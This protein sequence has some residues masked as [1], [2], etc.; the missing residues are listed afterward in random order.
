MQH[1]RLRA[2]SCPLEL[3]C[4]FRVSTLGKAEIARGGV[5]KRLYLILLLA[6]VAQ[7]AAALTQ[8]QE[9][10]ISATGFALFVGDY[11][12]PACE[13]YELDDQAVQSVWRSAGLNPDRY[14]EQA[15]FRGIGCSSPSA[16]NDKLCLSYGHGMEARNAAR[17]KDKYGDF[18]R[19]AW[20]DFGPG[21]KV[22]PGLLKERKP[23]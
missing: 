23:K 4:K 14:M 19:K 3:F 15:H 17:M 12:Y 20:E 5:M 6:T 13:Q 2:T 9:R 22:Q 16:V 8:Q 11:Y 10:V 18:C 21:G 7:K 1:N